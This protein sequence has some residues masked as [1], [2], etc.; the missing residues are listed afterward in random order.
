M[1]FSFKYGWLCIWALTFPQAWDICS[2]SALLHHNAVSI[3]LPALLLSSAFVSV[4]VSVFGC[5]IFCLNNPDE[6]TSCTDV[7]Q[8]HCLPI[9]DSEMANTAW[10]MNIEHL[11]FPDSSSQLPLTFITLTEHCFIKSY[12]FLMG[13]EDFFR[14]QSLH[15]WP[16]DMFCGQN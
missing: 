14:A 13:G 11:H 9:D 16:K 3:P 12:I 4:Q 8:D 7:R 10:Y 15:D 2:L 6:L 5:Y 1:I